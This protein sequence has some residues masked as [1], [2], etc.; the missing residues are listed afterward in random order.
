M[1]SGNTRVPDGIVDDIVVF[2]VPLSSSSPLSLD[3]SL[4]HCRR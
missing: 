1:V 3:R 4:A 2:F